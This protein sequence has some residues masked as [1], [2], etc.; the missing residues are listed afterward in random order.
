MRHQTFIKVLNNLSVGEIILGLY[1]GKKAISKGYNFINPEHLRDRIDA[2]YHEL[3]D[4][5][6]ISIYEVER[7]MADDEY[8]NKIRLIR[9]LTR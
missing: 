1:N 2:Y 8:L 5:R 6:G 9:K 3:C 7:L 4:T